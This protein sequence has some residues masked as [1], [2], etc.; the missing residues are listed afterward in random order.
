MGFLIISA[1]IVA[2]VLLI[3]MLPVSITKANPRTHNPQYSPLAEYG[4]GFIMFFA[5][6]CGFYFLWFK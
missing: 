6:L 1:K 4:A 5:A 3:V 2:T